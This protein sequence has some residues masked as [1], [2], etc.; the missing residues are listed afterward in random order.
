MNISGKPEAQQASVNH[1]H[2]HS[3]STSYKE[4]QEHKSIKASKSMRTPHIHVNATPE[5]KNPR[6]GISKRHIV[7]EKG[8]DKK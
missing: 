7:Q 6:R 1:H 4:Q 3:S 5:N 2:H 8:V